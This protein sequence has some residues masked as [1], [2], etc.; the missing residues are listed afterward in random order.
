MGK[1]GE[2]V[3]K[4]EMREGEVGKEGRVGWTTIEAAGAKTIEVSVTRWEVA[5]GTRS[6]PYSSSPQEM[7]KE[8]YGKHAMKL[9][10]TSIFWHPIVLLV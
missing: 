2:S 9:G 4:E 7:N 5:F 8:V 3:G 10:N 1:D 6:V